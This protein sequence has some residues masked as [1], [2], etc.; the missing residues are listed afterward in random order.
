[1]RNFVG[2]FRYKKVESHAKMS[3]KEGVSEN[4][5]NE[6]QKMS[7]SNPLEHFN[8]VNACSD[9]NIV[10]KKDSSSLNNNV[11]TSP[12]IVSGCVS[13]S[14]KSKL[15]R[16]VFRTVHSKPTTHDCV[17]SEKDSSDALSKNSPLLSAKELF[18]S[19]QDLDDEDFELDS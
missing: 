19:Q 12:N 2:K 7:E 1:M 11:E 5:V 4:V 13:S 8:V 15:G 9:A 14:T 17:S 16:F 10:D 3:K 18:S 6:G